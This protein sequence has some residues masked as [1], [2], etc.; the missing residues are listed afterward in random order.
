[1]TDQSFQMAKVFYLVLELMN[2]YFLKCDFCLFVSLKK[3]FKLDVAVSTASCSFFFCRIAENRLHMDT[4][5]VEN[6]HAYS[7]D[8]IIL[9]NIDLVYCI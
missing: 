8:K 4:I 6:D 1:M 2:I 7:V 9:D 5:L 3:I